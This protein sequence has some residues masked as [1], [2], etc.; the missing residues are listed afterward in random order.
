MTRKEQI[1]AKAALEVKIRQ[2]EA[3]IKSTIKTV[4]NNFN[5]KYDVAFDSIYNMA[6]YKDDVDYPLYNQCNTLIKW[7]NSMWATARANQD[8]VIAG[9]MTDSEFVAALPVAPV[10]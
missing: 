7:Q 1:L 9:T 5:V 2:G 10:V 6:I 3:Y 8:F 4:V